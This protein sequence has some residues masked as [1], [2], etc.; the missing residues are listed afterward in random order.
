[1]RR[2]ALSACAALAAVPGFVYAQD[3]EN[4][5]LFEQMRGWAIAHDAAIIV[6]LLPTPAIQYT[7]EAVEF[8]SNLALKLLPPWLEAPDSISVDPRSPV[9]ANA[10]YWAAGECAIEFRL[11]SAQAEYEN[12]FGLANF[13]PAYVDPEDGRSYPWH[14]TS[15]PL[16]TRW[17][18]LR[19]PTVYHANTTVNLTVGARDGVFRYDSLT[20][21]FEDERT[22]PI[23]LSEEP[24][25][26][27]LPIGEHV[28]QWRAATE[29]DWISDVAVPG[30]LLAFGVLT[31]LKNAYPGLKFSRQVKDVGI[32]ETVIR[33]GV[34]ADAARLT[35]GARR[36][37]D[38]WKRAWDNR[39]NRKWLR[40]LRKNVGCEF[41]SVM[42]DVLDK[43]FDNGVSVLGATTPDE[44]YSAGHITR[45]EKILLT[46]IFNV[47]VE[48]GLDLSI[49]AIN[50]GLT[51][52]DPR[53]TIGAVIEF[54][55]ETADEEDFKFTDY[56]KREM[57]VSVRSQFVFVYDSVP[58]TIALS[59]EPLVVEAS[60]FGGTRLHR[61]RPAL[62][63]AAEAGASDNCGRR[64][65]LIL[66]APDLLPL[67][68]NEVTWIARDLGPNPPDDPRDFAPTAI[69]PIVVQDTQP[70][71]LLA[72]PSK[73]IEAAGA[74]PL[75][76]AGIGDA[77]AVD[78]V[79]VQ[80]TVEHNAPAAF[81]LDRR[82]QVQWTATDQSGNSATAVQRITVKTVGTNTEPV[83]NPATARTLTA[84]PVD[85]RLTALDA[86]V[87]DGVAD[88]VWFKIE[89]QP[90]R[91]E[92]VAP[93][94]PFFI[95]D[96]RTRPNDGLGDDFDPTTDDVLE[97]LEQ[98]YCDEDL[99]PRPMPLN[100]VHEARFVHVTDDGIRYV[101]DE[102]FECFD[103]E[104]AQPVARFSKWNAAGEFIGQARLGTSS[105]DRPRD[106]TF[107][108]DRDGFLYYYVAT[109]PGS[110]SNELGLIRCG[111]DWN[112]ATHASQVCLRAS[113]FDGSSAPNSGLDAGTLRLAR[114]DSD[115]GVAYVADAT[116][117]FSFEL[118]GNG[119]T[120]YIGE[121][122]P[123]IE[124]AVVAGWLGRPQALEVGSDGSVYVAD[125]LHHRIHKIG[126]V[127]RD[128][129]DGL[130]PGDYV[131]WAGR[132]T[133]SGNR[134]CDDE[135][136][137]SRGYSC[138][139]E[140]QSCTVDAA[141]RSG[142]AQGQFNTPRF[143]AIDPNDILY[144]ADYENARIQRLSADGSFAGEAVSD[145]SGINKGDRPSFVVGNMGRP[146]SVSVNSSQFYVVDRDE[147]F[148][149]VF[150]T[151][152]FKN[153][154]DDAV[155]VTY[156]SDQD[157]PNPNITGADA[158]TFSVTDGL[159]RSAPATVEVTVDR[160]FRA[161]IAI[162]GTAITDE[163]VP[164]DVELEA[165]DPDG[166]AGRDFLGLD[167]LTYAVTALPANGELTG[168]GESW[169]YLPNPG[170]SGEDRFTFRVN[171][172]RDDSNEATFTLEV[173]PSND[174]PEV[175]IE[176]PRRVPLGFPT[177]L[178]AT[179]FDDPAESYEARIVWGDGT[180]SVTGEITDGQNNDP[181][182]A[183]VFVTDPPAPG[184]EGRI[185]SQHV[186]EVGGSRTVTVCLTDDAGLEGC[187]SLNI[188]V[189][190]LVQLGFGAVVYDEPLAEGEDTDQEMLDGVPFTYEITLSNGLP[191]VGDGLSAQD[192][193]LDAELPAGLNVTDVEISQ[194]SCTVLGLAVRCEIG[195]L[196]PDGSATFEVRGYGPGTL[197]AT[198]TKDLTGVLSTT[199][200]A[201]EPEIEFIANIDLVPNL[202]DPDGD[203]IPE[204]YERAYG[205]DLTRDD[206]G[207]DA[208]G[209]GLDNRAEFA[210]GT[211]PRAADTD[212]DG[213]TDFTEYRAGTSD[214]TRVDTD[215][216][217]MPDGWEVTHGLAPM[218]PADA[219]ED[220]DDDGL[221]NGDEFAL[222]KDPRRDDVPPAV[223]PPTDVTVVATG[224]LTRVA[225]GIGAAEDARD[226]AVA[227]H[228]SSDGPFPPGVSIVSWSAEDLLGNGATAVQRVNVIPLAT[229]AVDQSVAEGG[230]AVVR[231][232]L[233]GPA[234]SYP[235]ILP[236][237][238][239]GSADYAIDHA[240]FSGTLAIASG[241]DG[242]IEI[243]TL[244]D[245]L[246]DPNETIV[247]TMGSLAN[248]A[249]GP[250]TTHTITI[251]EGNLPPGVSVLMEQQGRAV[252]TVARDSGAVAVSAGVLDSPGQS[253]GFDWSRSDRGAFD[254]ARVASPSYTLDPL[255]LAETVHAL[256]V[257]VTDNGL[258]VARGEARTLLR[259]VRALPIMSAANDSD[260][261]GIDDRSEGTGD[262]DGD[263]VPDYLDAIA[264]SNVLLLAADGPA[265]EAST[266][267]SVRLGETAFA[268]GG[269]HVA[270]AE[271]DVG[272][273]V[274]HGYVNGV[275]DFEILGLEPGGRAQVVIALL[276][277]ITAGAVYRKFLFGAWSDWREAG[278]DA[279]ASAPG[280][281]GVC[282]PPGGDAYR[283]GLTVGDGCL[284]LT[285][286]DGGPNDAD[287]APN[288]VIRDPG[289]LA[290]P[291]AV[292]LEVVPLTTTRTTSGGDVVMLELKLQSVSGD[293][294]LKSL[295][296]AAGGTGDDRS[297]DEVLLVHDL[298]GDGLPDHGEPMLASGSY[299]SNNGSLTLELVSEFEVPFGTT[300]VLVVYRTGAGAN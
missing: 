155:T 119:G 283:P 50:A 267:L 106:D 103:D 114:I 28:I 113:G 286:T 94:Y 16:N 121:V 139:F 290:V 40:E 154:A 126:A 156:V 70:P 42:V 205:L 124:G 237:T 24:Q 201:V 110:S 118:L 287:G 162:D 224:R 169:T 34:D 240:G 62:L 229:F 59:P 37:G 160:N 207:E 241:I 120:R 145:G 214:P 78:L 179:F 4:D 1:M 235:V 148:V 300:D 83:A 298:D 49:I 271:D 276:R 239:S 231:V 12:M 107:V 172:G 72:P 108:V 33:A 263:R 2:L 11:L 26:V 274:D 244:P 47:W 196:P 13:R 21:T 85:I 223:R 135:L 192:V 73:V 203:G 90:A 149:H 157:F 19:A 88:P 143:I 41:M 247:L 31:E 56:L 166:I 123:T 86:D 273:D 125:E 60:D 222:G 84:Q 242:R 252:T 99:P 69:Q 255:A 200:E 58:P 185:F 152:P 66:V 122:G 46:A 170:F 96:Y 173:T 17:G 268:L 5:A 57:Q 144:V 291:V 67:G 202:A 188:F 258:P 3:E 101:L 250:K 204:G 181:E 198:A 293:A 132:C 151:L 225:L 91:G 182:V 264:H 195:E 199:A 105:S 208:D 130:V 178:R 52:D 216:D 189:E 266:G 269:T 111:T 131:G 206:G 161:P 129:E 100:F 292:T 163:D 68:S 219:S 147:Q 158:F 180:S 249:P 262:S 137:R 236:Y 191:S 288:G 63:A 43:A 164:V 29:L 165:D 159:V 140:A 133:G 35:E 87:L 215:G 53:E 209:D 197:T 76:S 134:A 61:V 153:I 115:A 218:V 112:A 74:V 220:P 230:T 51:C 142:G 296:L 168:Q 54:L 30:A 171:D 18:F 104:D 243:P 233:N 193:A 93:L 22:A 89:S 65:E 92:F 265:I 117:L 9:P 176:Q 277:P 259:V 32:S 177:L 213:L 150:G 175:T 146:A 136:G 227:M 234:V 8:S 7:G 254:P 98:N 186:Y 15:D 272:T 246:A 82:T 228:A 212:G 282:P 80:P 25:I 245:V 174:P 275:A 27:H 210:L 77:A 226:G 211:S 299:E 190:P 20:G 280:A 44:L 183:G 64:P 79:D 297:I 194:G 81:P 102:F 36:Y 251:R 48:R 284:E 260:G 270:I 232:E 10:N 128:A 6:G 217:G 295:A 278:G 285:L 75:A 281:D 184:V 39:Q 38:V 253:H 55:I 23:L 238:I 141:N 95:E 256:E 97:F 14:N 221:A 71:L 45:L 257:R 138:T 261:D 294:V 279:L 109:Q 167:T 187:D 289:G 127:R 248:A 116:Q